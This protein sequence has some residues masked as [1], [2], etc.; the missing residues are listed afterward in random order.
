[1]RFNYRY[2]LSAL[3]IDELIT[4]HPGVNV[5]RSRDMHHGPGKVAHRLVRGNHII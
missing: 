4:T 2:Q 5:S 1:M 3:Q